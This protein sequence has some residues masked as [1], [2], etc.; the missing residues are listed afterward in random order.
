M[1]YT[2]SNTSSNSII[3]YSPIET[4]TYIYGVETR[5]II[6][7]FEVSVKFKEEKGSL[8]SYFS[9]YVYYVYDGLKQISV[10]EKDHELTDEE[11]EYL[12]HDESVKWID[13]EMRSTMKI[14]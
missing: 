2:I 10:F 4:F 8:G 3:W 6:F 12:L 7:P 14:A 1:T 5:K 11:L 13:K 9:S